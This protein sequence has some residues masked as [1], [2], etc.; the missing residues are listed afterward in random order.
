VFLD[1]F[2]QDHIVRF[3]DLTPSADSDPEKPLLDEVSQI[4]FVVDTTNS[5]P[6]S[7]GRFW[8]RSAAFQK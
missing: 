1:T 2:D 3:D 8:I 4:L 7:S 5:K 6:G